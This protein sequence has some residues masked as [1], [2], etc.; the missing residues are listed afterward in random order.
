MQFVLQSYKTVCTD[1]DINKGPASV[2]HAAVLFVK[3]RFPSLADKRMLLFGLGEIGETTLKNLFKNYKTGHITIINRTRSKAEELAKNLNVR[4]ADMED[5]SEEID[6]ADIVIVATGAQVPT[7][8]K[9][10]VTDCKDIEKKLL[11]DLSV[12]R[13][14]TLILSWTNFL[15]WI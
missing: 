7:V 3:E 1:T 8:T 11:L 5:L 2:A 10:H 14:I 15:V 13:N 12:P 6:L 4:V 9:G